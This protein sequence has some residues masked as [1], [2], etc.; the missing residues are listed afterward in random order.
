MIGDTVAPKKKK[1]P[2][3]VA[4]GRLG[5]VKGGKARAA[6]LTPEVRSEI[7][8]RAGKAGGQSRAKKMTKAQRSESARKAAAARWSKA[9]DE[10]PK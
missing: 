1:N 8:T 6:A 10:D 7:A 3:A 9:R 4:L 2:H 5:G